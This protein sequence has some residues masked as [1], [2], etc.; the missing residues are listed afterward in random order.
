MKNNTRFGFIDLGKTLAIIFI[1]LIHNGFSGLNNVVLFAMPLFFFCSGYLFTPGRRTLKQTA[2]AQF[3][4]VL[5]PF[6]GLMIVYA[7]VEL[8]RAPYVGYGDP[9]IIRPAINAIYGSSA[10]PNPNGI[11]DALRSIRTYNSD[12]RAIVLISPTYC[13]LW[14]L[15]AFFTASIIFSF[16]AERVRKLS[17]RIIAIIAL[18]FL[19]SLESTIPELYQLPYGIGRGFMGASFMLVGFQMRKI[20]IFEP[21]KRRVAIPLFVIG[22]CVAVVSILLGS[23]GGA[24]IVS[25]YGSY[26]ILSTYLTFLGGLGA[27]FCVLYICKL[28]SDAL[29]ISEKSLSSIIGRN[30][31]TIYGWHFLII[32]ILD[33]LYVNIF[34]LSF[35]PDA[36]YMALLPVDSAWWYMILKVVAVIAICIGFAQSRRST[37]H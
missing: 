17:F 28:L 7:V 33:V 18:V 29:S 23:T 9:E 10:L 13:H 5:L 4:K 25:Y 2:I 21:Q 24:Y 31:M 19:S 16:I 8:I 20:A 12:P 30:T 1:L 27:L 35:E 15:P 32:F 11:F 14:F 34:S 26:G 22:L 37:Y 6:W 36:Y 3:K